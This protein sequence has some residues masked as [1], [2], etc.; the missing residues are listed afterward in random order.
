M[1]NFT[2]LTPERHGSWRWQRYAAYTFAAQ[3][4]IAPLVVTELPRA[5]L[6]LPVGFIAQGE[7]FAPVALLGLT[8]GQNLQVTPEGHWQVDAYI[9]AVYRSY[10]FQLLPTGEGGWVLGV[11]EDSGLL[12]E[13]EGEPFFTADGQAA[14]VVQDILNFLTQLLTQR[15]TTQPMCAALQQQGL[16]QPW[17]I[18]VQTPDGTQTVEGLYRVDEAALNQLPDAAFLDLRRAGALPIAYC[19]LLSMQHLPR[20]GQLAQA[21]IAP[22]AALPVPLT[23]ELDLDGFYR[24]EVVTFGHWD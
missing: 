1:S 16:I 11:D 23:G 6:S 17:P 13:T 10:P 22:A 12:T 9:P 24:Q 7:A 18:T 5:I 4:L 20:L 8:P 15:Q 2:P 19:Q 21:R 3:D 14:P